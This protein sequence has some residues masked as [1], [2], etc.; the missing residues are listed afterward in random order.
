MG[1]IEIKVAGSFGASCTIRQFSAM[2]NGHAD[3]VAKAIEFLAGQLLPD[4]ISL[5]HQL[6]KEGESPLIGFGSKGIKPIPRA[7]QEPK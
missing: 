4:A 3:C 5:D 2:E 1:R 7:A 6:A